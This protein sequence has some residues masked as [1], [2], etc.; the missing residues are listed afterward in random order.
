M[1]QIFLFWHFLHMKFFIYNLHC[2]FKKINKNN[3]ERFFSDIKK[4]VLKLK[5]IVLK[6]YDISPVVLKNFQKQNHKFFFKTFIYNF[7]VIF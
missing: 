4:N 3:W 7:C 6:V 1:A 2:P 5:F